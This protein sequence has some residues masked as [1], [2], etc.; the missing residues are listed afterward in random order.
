M[1]KATKWQDLPLAIQKFQESERIRA[2]FRG[3][4]FRDSLK[5]IALTLL[6][7]IQSL[8]LGVRKAALLHPTHAPG[9]S[10]SCRTK[11]ATAT[12]RTVVPVSAG[13]VHR[14]DFSNQTRNVNDEV[15]AANSQFTKLHNGR[16]P[17]KGL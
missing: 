7:R 5:T 4:R 14:A 10:R 11:T 3:V 15:R 2:G 9:P 8:P 6:P 12:S 1:Y 17:E 13:F 16:A